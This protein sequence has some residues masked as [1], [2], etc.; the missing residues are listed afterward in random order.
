MVGIWISVRLIGFFILQSDRKDRI[1]VRTVRSM[2]FFE[3]QIK[4]VLATE[5]GVGPV[6]RLRDE[7]NWS[8]QLRADRE[9]Y[10]SEDEIEDVRR[11]YA[12]VAHFAE[13]DHRYGSGSLV[14]EIIARA[15]GGRT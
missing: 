2:R 1:R 4:H 11:F 15:G 5:F 6:Q 9:R 14:Y 3:S 13:S 10:L 8:K 12:L 7:L